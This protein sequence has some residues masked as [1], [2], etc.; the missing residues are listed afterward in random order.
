MSVF[1]DT[2]ALYALLDRDDGNHAW[3][4]RR[5]DR[6]LDE[7]QLVTHNYVLVES[8]TLA[9]RRLG[10]DAARALRRSLRPALS[11][12]WVDQGLHDTATTAMLASR[13]RRL[14]LVDCVSFEVMRRADIEVAF[15]FDRSFTEQGFLT[16]D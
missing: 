2:S 9:Q 12:V 10:T 13:R 5:F 3:A 6:L 11:V 1:I 8:A 7:E 15:A 4:A 14:S 16:L